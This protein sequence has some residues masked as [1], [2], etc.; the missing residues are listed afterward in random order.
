MLSVLKYS[1]SLLAALVITI[2][3]FL[4]IQRL[5]NQPLPTLPEFDYA[6]TLALSQIPPSEPP[7]ETEPPPPEEVLEPMMET[8]VVNL[9]QV[10]NVELTLPEEFVFSDSSPDALFTTDAGPAQVQI[11]SELLAEFGEDTRRGFIEITPFATRKPNIPEMAWQHQLNGWVLIAFNV[12]AA[13]KTRNIKV[14]DAHPKGV[15][16]AEVIRAIQQWRYAV[17]DHIKNGQ[18]LVLTQK[19]NLQ[20]QDYP[21]NLPYPE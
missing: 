20:W 17:S 18:D 12:S 1:S 13:G 3:L 10:E 2:L 19:I 6:G 16:E 21:Q 8:P 14:L 11:A 9:A 7:Q 15:F 4:F 5:V